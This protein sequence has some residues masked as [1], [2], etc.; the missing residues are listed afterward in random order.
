MRIAVTAQ[1]SSLDSQVSS[2]FGRCPDFVFVDTDTMA[3]EAVPNPAAGSQGGAGVRAASFAVERG[4]E[5]VV[6]GNIGPN[7]QRV[8]GNAGLEVFAAES[9]T[10]RQAVEAFRAGNLKRLFP[11]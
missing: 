10:V 5:A 1:G 8:L 11:R 2:V 9:G 4:A 7:V 3:F 6:T